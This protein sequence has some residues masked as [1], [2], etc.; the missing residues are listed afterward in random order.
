MIE[1]LHEHDRL[2]TVLKEHVGLAA[3]RPVGQPIDVGGISAGAVNQKSVY[4]FLVHERLNR[5][6]TPCHLL[7]GKRRIVGSLPHVSFL[8]RMSLY[9]K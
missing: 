6:V 9:L 2:F 5:P 7:I 1:E 8:L 4:S 3:A